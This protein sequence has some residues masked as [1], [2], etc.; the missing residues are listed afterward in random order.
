MTKLSA[1][2]F[3]S[4][5]LAQS[6]IATTLSRMN[7]DDLTAE[8]PDIVYGKIIASR[9][10]W[11]QGHTTI[12]TVYTVQPYDYLKGQLG[13][14]F[15][16]EE[17]GGEL[18]GWRV[19]V[20]GVPVFSVGDEEVLFVWTDHRGRHQVIGYEQGAIAVRSD[21][22]TGQRLA[23]RAVRL[24]SSSSQVSGASGPFSS[25]SLSEL[26]AQIRSSIAKTSRTGATR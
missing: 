14:T 20:P 7:L 26:L 18:D 9:V 21:S 3:L 13:S 16:L 19:Y 15:E 8:S 25:L 23:S 12:Q 1:L 4:C 5:A 6:A 10:E 11:D 17:I 24:G 2:I 22:S